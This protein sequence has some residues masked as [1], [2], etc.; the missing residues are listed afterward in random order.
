MA[1]N[2]PKSFYSHF[3]CTLI[4]NECSR[5]LIKDRAII[6]YNIEWRKKINSSNNNT[7]I[8]RKSGMRPA[9]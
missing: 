9:K 8:T 1:S 5:V 3:I 2:I 6:N 4:R 7:M